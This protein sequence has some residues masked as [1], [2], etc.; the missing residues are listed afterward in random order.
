MP[1]KFNPGMVYFHPNKLKEWYKQHGWTLRTLAEE[2]RVN[3]STIQNHST[4][5]QGCRK[6]FFLLYV[7]VFGKDIISTVEIHRH[8]A[9]LWYERETGEKLDLEGLET[10][11]EVT[12]SEEE[13]RYIEYFN[14][15]SKLQEEEFKDLRYWIDLA[16][17]ENIALSQGKQKTGKSVNVIDL[18]EECEKHGENALIYG[19]SGS[20]KTLTCLKLFEKFR[21]KF[22][23]SK[24]ASNERIPLFVEL[25]QINPDDFENSIRGKIDKDLFEQDKDKYIIFLDGLN[26][27]G[28]VSKQ[29][30]VLGKI[31]RFA[32]LNPNTRL[33]ITTQA[34]DTF[35]NNLSGFLLYEIQPLDKTNV[36]DYLTKF[37]DKFAL[38]K[39]AETF[40]DDFTDVMREF[41]SIPVFLKNLVSYYEK[42]KHLK[43][44]NPGQLF[45][46]YEDFLC[47]SGKRFRPELKKSYRKRF[48]PFLAF[49]MCIEN[50][51]KIRWDRFNEYVQNYNK[52]YNSSINESDVE[53]AL[54]FKFRIMKKDENESLEFQHQAIRDY[55]A[56]V[57]MLHMLDEKSKA[58]KILN[59]VYSNST[60]NENIINAVK[61]LAGIAEPQNSKAII[62]KSLEKDLYLACELFAWSSIDTYDHEIVESIS[63]KIKYDSWEYRTNLKSVFR[64]YLKALDLWQKANKHDEPISAFFRLNLGIA[65]FL[66][67]DFEMVIKHCTEAI[68][69]YE[70]SNMGRCRY[71]GLCFELI[72]CAHTHKFDSE[73]AGKYLEKAKSI[74]EEHNIKP[75]AYFSNSGGAEY[76]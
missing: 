20:G 46:K 23:Q 67:G 21:E 25:S 44:G 31:V 42:D 5:I 18:V 13:S 47:G 71:V 72:G 3:K 2:M 64:F 7:E 36:I 60:K 62:Q 29:Q 49:N 14:S 26:E 75:R 6:P 17:I 28:D 48:L 56:G 50:E 8:L 15:I 68:S 54:S 69:I 53:E 37:Q 73:T 16:A 33:F 57:H 12:T 24:S 55:F 39:E 40:F 22:S 66:E 59:H 63:D 10:Q 9:K 74:S 61:F 38:Q 11:I 34:F 76:F 35:Y 58:E 45:Q 43:I 19:Q 27:V 51:I 32:R 30:R 4:Q 52:K 65:Y 1:K 41:L 70:N